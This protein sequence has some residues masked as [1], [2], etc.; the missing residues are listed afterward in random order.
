MNITYVLLICALLIK[1]IYIPLNRRKSK[2]YWKIP[3]DNKI[4]LI[5]VFVIPYAL[6]HLGVYSSFFILWKTSYINQFLLSI[7]V[8]YVIAAVFWYL[9]PN[10]VSRPTLTHNSHLYKMLRLI[11]KHDGDTNGFP[12]AHV[13][14]SLI[15]GHFLSL[16]FP[17]AVLIIWP[18]VICIILSTVFIKQHYVIDILGG[19][20]VY[21]LTLIIIFSPLI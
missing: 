14:V 12:S 11:Y 3:F 16:A 17:A 8:S 1:S 9:F 2:F 18:L 5:P 15:C 7:I 21:L 4:P 6:Y 13:F 10:G 20:V 19:M